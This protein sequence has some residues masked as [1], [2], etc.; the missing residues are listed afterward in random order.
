M[1]KRTDVV[2]RAVQILISS[3]LPCAVCVTKLWVL[4]WNVY[5][6]LIPVF[7]HTFVGRCFKLYMWL[8]QLLGL[9]C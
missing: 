6:R 7:N 5:F 4:Q 8:L 9:A 3:V 1:K 2:F